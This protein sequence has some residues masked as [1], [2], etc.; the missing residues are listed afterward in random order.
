M[1]TSIIPNLRTTLLALVALAFLMVLPLGKAQGATTYPYSNLIYGSAAPAPISFTPS[2][3]FNGT[4]YADGKYP[5]THAYIFK[6]ASGKPWGHNLYFSGLTGPTWF[7]ALY[8]IKAQ[9][10]YNVTISKNGTPLPQGSSVSVGDT[11]TL[12]FAPHSSADISWFA[13]GYSVLFLKTVTLTT[14]DTPYGQWAANAAAPSSCTASS[15]NYTWTWSGWYI[16]LPFAVN[17]PT[18]TIQV[19]SGLTCGPLSSS[20]TMT[21]TVN[22]SAANTT[23]TP[24]FNFSSTYGEF[25]YQI[26]RPSPIASN[27]VASTIPMSATSGGAPYQLPIPAQTISYP[28]TVTSST[29]PPSAPTLICPSSPVIAGSPASFS[30]SGTDPSNLPVR[31]GMDYVNVG[32]VNAWVPAIGYVPSGTPETTTYTWSAPGTYTVHALTENST[33]ADSPWASC[34]V[35]VVSG[36]T[37]GDC[38]STHYSCTAGTSANNVSG[39]SAWTWQ[40]TGA[41]GGTTASCSEQKP[42]TSVSF[43]CG[44]TLATSASSCT[45]SSG[46]PTNLYWSSTPG[47]SCTSPGFSTAGG[48]PVST[49]PL[50]TN[51]TLYSLT[52]VGPNNAPST[53][54]VTVNVT[55]PNVS[56]SANPDRVNAGDKSTISWTSSLVNS[57]TVTGPT[58]NTFFSNKTNNPGGT[59]VTINFQ[60]VY[61]ISC[62]VNGT[63]YSASTTV[64]ILPKFNEF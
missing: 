50:F 12:S 29:P 49:G 61:T 48:S 42:L 11:L 1:K 32:S 58:P 60:S 51:P 13:G 53:V 19:P 31:Y 21:C 56:I 18:E 3:S 63:P 2:S 35:P 15:N 44:K 23:L 24:T 52:C 45:V 34:T 20:G 7:P 64:N 26:S 38:A 37:N 55:Q 9:V 28:L 10:G 5:Y 22:S 33:T 57:C 4:L 62:T 39:A 16:Y 47:T 46:Q 17:P 54:N 43:T 25:Y 27:C 14:G 30:I 59:K 40:C 36:P 6:S 8:A 41:N